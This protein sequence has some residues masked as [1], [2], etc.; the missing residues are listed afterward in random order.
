MSWS[1]FIDS[2]FCVQLI[3]TLAHFLW[4]ATV[5]ALVAGTA[6]I[7]LRRATAQLRYVVLLVALVLMAASP[8]MTF[9]L[10]PEP[11]TLEFTEPAQPLEAI[12]PAEA[13]VVGP[14]FVEPG[15]IAPAE[16]IAAL[17]TAPARWEPQQHRRGRET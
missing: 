15:A 5:I 7:L 1:S 16:T 14:G 10:L 8:V 2:A 17:E 12:L 3:L 13:L 9:V 11:T 6:V 4:Q